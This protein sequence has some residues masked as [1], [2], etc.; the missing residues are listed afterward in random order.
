MWMN[1]EY[2]CIRKY[3]VRKL[4]DMCSL[5]PWQKKHMQSW[6]RSILYIVAAIENYV[7]IVLGDI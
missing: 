3:I 6:R 2:L 7:S 5:M 1:S 4:M